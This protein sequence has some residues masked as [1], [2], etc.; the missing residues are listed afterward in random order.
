MN[1]REGISVFPVSDDF[2]KRLEEMSRYHGRGGGGND[3]GMEPRIARLEALAERSGNDLSEIRQDMRD[4]RDRLIRLEEKV[5]HLP[6]KTSIFI[7]A[8]AIVGAAGTI[9]ALL[10]AYQDFLKGL[11][12]GG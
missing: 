11:A 5:S 2:Q 4:S 10:I 7:A 3:G 8:S 9:M 12:V 6:T 1:D